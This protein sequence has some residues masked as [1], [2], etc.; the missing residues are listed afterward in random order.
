MIRTEATGYGLCYF[1]QALL[2]DNGTSFEGKTVTISGSG[3]VA[4]YACEK[5]TQ[6][7]AKVVTMS[8]SNGFVYDPEGFDL[9]LV[10]D[11]KEVRRGRI[12]E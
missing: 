6:L 5:A 10:K 2:K 11:I 8:D 1:T 4:I 12:K 3:N 9:D 7:G